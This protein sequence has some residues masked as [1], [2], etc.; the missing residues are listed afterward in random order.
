MLNRQASKKGNSDG[1]TG[2]KS[3]IRT[4]KSYQKTYR[5]LSKKSKKENALDTISK[6]IFNLLNFKL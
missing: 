5:R 1:S 6:S 4:M 2:S 3:K